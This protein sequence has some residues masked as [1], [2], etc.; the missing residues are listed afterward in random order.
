MWEIKKSNYLKFKLWPNLDR[1]LESDL[2]LKLEVIIKC[3]CICVKLLQSC[4]TLCNNMDCSLPGSSLHGIL[5]VRIL[6]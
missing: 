4:L 5:Q 6:E 2:E 1:I 3:M